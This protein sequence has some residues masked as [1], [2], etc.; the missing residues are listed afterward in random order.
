MTYNVSGGIKPC[1]INQFGMPPEFHREYLIM[2]PVK[3]RCLPRYLV[4]LVQ[5]YTE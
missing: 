3:E 2:I 5:P 1:S 4:Y